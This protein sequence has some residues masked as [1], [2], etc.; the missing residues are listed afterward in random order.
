MAVARFKSKHGP[1][2]VQLSETAP[3][4]G[5]RKLVAKGKQPVLEASST[6]EDALGRIKPIADALADTIA[7]LAIRPRETTVKFGIEFSGELGV[8]LASS[9]LSASIE[10]TL[11]WERDE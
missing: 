3:A 1:I 2:Y 8:I 11:A 5:D 10:V 6:F 4:D 9:K 7:A